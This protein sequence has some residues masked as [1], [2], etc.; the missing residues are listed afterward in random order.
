MGHR[1]INQHVVVNVLISMIELPRGGFETGAFYNDESF[2]EITLSRHQTE[3]A[4]LNEFHRL[5]G[6]AYIEATKLE[7]L[8]PLPGA[9]A[10]RRPPHWE[11]VP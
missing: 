3:A 2:K 11:L 5:V 8:R 6:A 10:L 9:T 4:A 7:N 1:I